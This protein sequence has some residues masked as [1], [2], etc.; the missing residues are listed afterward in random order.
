MG[1]DKDNSAEP[2]QIHRK[3]GFSS[4]ARASL[5][6]IP[7][8]LAARQSIRLCLGILVIDRSGK[9]VRGPAVPY[10]AATARRG[11]DKEEGR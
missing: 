8:H 10:M 3:T 7:S 5:Y 9:G 2:T 11:C 1:L 6:P 4:P